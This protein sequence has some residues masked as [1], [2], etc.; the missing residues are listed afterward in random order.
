M[1]L[2]RTL[3]AGLCSGAVAASAAL[4][5][6]PH[7]GPDDAPQFGGELSFPFYGEVVA[8][9]FNFCPA[10]W[11][12]ADGH[13]YSAADYAS[14]YSVLLNAYGG[15]VRQGTFNVPDMRGRT[16]YGANAGERP[17]G[18]YGVATARFA[19]ANLES[20]T[21]V[22]RGTTARTTT[23]NPAGAMLGAFPGVSSY[24]QDEP[25]T[26]AMGLGSVSDTGA[27]APFPVRHPFLALT[28]C[29]ANSGYYPAHPN[30][31][32]EP[33][34]MMDRNIGDLMMTGGWF[35]PAGFALANGDSLSSAGGGEA[36]SL[37]TLIGTTY[38]GT[39]TGSFYNLPNLISRSPV[40]TNFGIANAPWIPLPM[41][42]Q[43]GQE[44][45]SGLPPHTHGL[46]ASSDA[47]AS[48]SP[49]GHYLATFPAGGRYASGATQAELTDMSSA[50]LGFSGSNDPQALPNLAPATAL[51]MCV[52]MDAVY[53]GRTMDAS[54]A[55]EAEEAEDDEAGAARRFFR[56]LRFWDRDDG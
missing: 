13:Q 4:A 51:N 9:A 43:T 34:T 48:N 40:G 32:H 3:F 41:G 22:V 45:I 39:R 38:G 25:G 6:T 23:P 1:T 29:I 52:T 17:R 15:D 14:L 26:T 47:P 30:P 31:R 55:S 7:H 12:P 49:A 36:T 42:A 11:L 21:H 16:P 50:M 54:D 10:G 8:M 35:C 5:Q 2:F 44:T 27:G 28:Y 18:Y 37:Y 46:R 19:L 33:P 24:S 20:H 56:R 53:P